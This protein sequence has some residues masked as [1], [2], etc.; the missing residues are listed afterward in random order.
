[1]SSGLAFHV[2]NNLKTMSMSYPRDENED[3]QHAVSAISASQLGTKKRKKDISRP[4]LK[5][6]LKYMWGLM[7]SEDEYSEN[8][9]KTDMEPQATVA[10]QRSSDSDEETDVDEPESHGAIPLLNPQPGNSLGSSE[11]ISK[12]RGPKKQ[13]PSASS[14]NTLDRYFRRVDKPEFDG[15]VTLKIGIENAEAIEKKL[16]LPQPSLIVKLRYKRLSMIVKLKYKRHSHMVKLPQRQLPKSESQ[17]ERLKETK[18]ISTN[19]SS[20]PPAKAPKTIHPFFLKRQGM[21]F[22]CCFSSC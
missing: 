22:Q 21:N 17:K 2:N 18:L 3:P 13:K 1:M 8:L 16:A 5:G 11:K 14:F 10:S 15:L 7:T 6:T 19:S 20:A 9:D 12:K 4:P